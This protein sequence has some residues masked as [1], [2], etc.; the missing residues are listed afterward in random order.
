MS[1]RD[2]LVRL[3]ERDGKLTAEAIVSEATDPDSPLHPTF[4]WDDDQAAHRWRL[5]QAEH[6]IRRYKIE[7][8]VA[9][10]R[11]VR[12]RQFTHIASVGGYLSTD[13]ALSHHRDE[14]FQQAV[15]DLA[16]F[17]VK[18]EALVDVEQAWQASRR[19]AR[20]AKAS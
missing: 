3:W 17:R 16:A 12:V 6:L 8:E 13:H 5:S 9:P 14:V 10:E 15:D 18:Y 2:E 19:R 20:K 11:T 7:I 4:E 1:I